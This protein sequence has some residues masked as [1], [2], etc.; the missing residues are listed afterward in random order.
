MN[1]FKFKF[2][3]FF[4]ANYSGEPVD[5]FLHPKP[6]YGLSVNPNND[7][8]FSTAG[9][10]GRVLMFDLRTSQDIKCVVKYRAPFHAVMF[11]PID[12]SFVITANAKEGAALW[13]LRTE[14]M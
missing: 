7:N 5:V 4:T 11:H 12:D 3:K 6:V 2:S 14:K 1:R 10:D 9:E 8:I 13:D